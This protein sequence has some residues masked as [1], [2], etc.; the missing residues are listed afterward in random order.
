M[1]PPGAYQKGGQYAAGVLERHTVI[2]Q[3]LVLALGVDKKAAHSDAC[4]MEHS[5]SDETYNTIKEKYGRSRALS[6]EEPPNY[7]DS[8]H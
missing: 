8:S 2:E 1:R 4:H 6:V 5:L 3:F 7:A